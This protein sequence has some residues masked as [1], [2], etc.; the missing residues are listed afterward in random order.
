M[1]LLENGMLEHPDEVAIYQH[2]LKTTP[3]A[4]LKHFKAACKKFNLQNI[5]NNSHEW[6]DIFFNHNIHTCAMECINSLLKR[7]D[8]T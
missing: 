5:I 4:S 6:E 7:H 3:T 2:Q 1:I 8:N